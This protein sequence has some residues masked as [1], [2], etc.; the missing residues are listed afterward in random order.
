[1]N[2]RDALD[3]ERASNNQ[4]QPVRRSARQG[5]LAR[6]RDW[7]TQRLSIRQRLTLWYASLLTLILTVL[8]AVTFTVA[9]NQIQSNLNADIRARAIAIAGALQHEE[10]T[11]SGGSSVLQPTATPVPSATPSITVTPGGAATPTN[12]AAPSSTPDPATN[13]AIQ[14]QLTVSVPASLGRLDLGFEV[15][16]TRG[17]LKYLAPSLN[18]RVLPIN[19]AVV[20]EALRGRSGAY[21][22]RSDGA[23]L[24]IYAQPII[25]DSRAL[26]RGG[27]SSS[28]P[29]AAAPSSSVSAQQVIGVVLVAKSQ[30]DVNNALSTLLR[31]LLVG[32]LIA[33]F[34]ATLGGWL[35]AE[36]GLRP[37]ATITRAASAIARN[38]SGAD[39]GTRVAYRGA[40]DE[41]GE[42]VSTFN[43]MLAAIQETAGAQR[44][45][46][47]DASHELRAPLTTIRGNLE[48]LRQ[49]HDLPE[50]DRSALLDDAYLE[51]ERM[52][53]LVSDLL[54]L[55]RVD[56]AAA[57]HGR[58]EADL[59]EQ[60][61]GRRE[62]VEIDQL[63]MDLL[64][65]GQAQL[66]VLHKQ[67]RLSVT[68]L[69]PV[70]VMADPGQLRQLG[71]IL[72]DN[73]LKYTPN[74]GQIRIAVTQTGPL[75]SLTVSDTGIGISREDLP[76]IF[77]RF[78]RAD[79]AR[80]RDEHGSG[81]GLAI[82][83]WIAEAHQGE[84]K[85]ESEAGRGSTFTVLL[86]VARQ[87]LSEQSSPRI[88]T[89]RRKRVRPRAMSPLAFTAIR[90]LARL[91]ESV[92]RPRTER[93]RL[94]VDLDKAASRSRR[95][96]PRIEQE[97]MDGA[98]DKDTS[99]S[100]RAV[101]PSNGRPSASG[102]RAVR[103]HSSPPRR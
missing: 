29:S 11:S 36:N 10:Y 98:S 9:Q 81:L 91:A 3:S 16:D 80:E 65:A 88:A 17:R 75:A 53:S 57:S 41:V 73:A 54:L 47:A 68:T 97:R 49:A 72:L 56:A 7:L 32:E 25:I 85:V 23:L 46:V 82:A 31:I 45:F 67:I 90:P 35:I 19:Y 77:E 18:G 15:L 100:R 44:R 52:T 99:R 58:G 83:Q 63:A 21:T 95:P 64:R 79:R 43:D 86:P 89:G 13:A 92:S 30:D 103:R 38:A 74:G 28:T 71:M 84:V 22:Q 26:A 5:T 12:T 27:A 42:L 61:T 69:A 2:E 76:H 102:E 70:R 48:L 55:A 40:K 33:I 60:L 1:M 94:D 14:R 50:H 96:R 59:R 34:C 24:S 8:S 78:Y 51:A 37:I 20:A 4:A 62:L 66:R 6:L 101:P 39:L 93:E 87:L